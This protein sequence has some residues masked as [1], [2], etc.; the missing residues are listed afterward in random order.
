MVLVDSNRLNQ[1]KNTPDIKH[2][3]HFPA[4]GVSNHQAIYTI[5]NSFTTKKEVKTY[6]F[7]NFNTLNEES[8]D[9]FANSIDWT[10]FSYESNIDSMIDNPYTIMN[11][12][13]DELCPYRTITSKY[14]PVPWMNEEIKNLM[15]KRKAF[16]DWWK[17]NRKHQSAD[18]IYSSF[19]KIDNEV[20]YAIR[21]SKK[22]SFIQNYNQAANSKDKWNL[23]HKFDVTKKAKK[24]ESHGEKFNNEFSLDKLN[25]H[26]SKL[27][28]LPLTNLELIQT[29]SRFDFSLITPEDIREVF[30]KI[31]SNGTR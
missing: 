17:L 20:K 10:I 18:L 21:A 4:I 16:Y 19:R 24:N 2:F 11:K 9:F 14:K 7:R 30:S 23:N 29:N 28:P 25:E 26:F 31:T 15:S 1:I 22:E 6:K 8:I 12:F 27:K 3:G 5:M 13:L